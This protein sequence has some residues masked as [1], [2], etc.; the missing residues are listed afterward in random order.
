MLLSIWLQLL[1]VL[2]GGALLTINE[3]ARF[4]AG[5]STPT[6]VLEPLEQ[7]PGWQR[8]SLALDAGW[9]KLESNRLS[10]MSAW[11]ETEI[12]PVI[13]AKL[14]LVYL[15]GGPDAITVDVIYA[16]APIYVLAGLERVG[17]VPALETLTPDEL[18]RGLSSLR[19]AIRTTIDQSFFI[20][21]KIGADLKRS[22]LQG[23]LP[24][25]LLMLARH[26][27]EVLEA[28]LMYLDEAGAPTPSTGETP[29]RGVPGLRLRFRRDGQGQPR[30]LYYFSQDVTN[31]AL[32][33]RP[34]L[35]PFLKSLGP[36]NSF[37]KAAS[38]ILHDRHFSKTRQAV[39]DG[40]RSILQDDSGVAFQHLPASKWSL[41]FYGEY[42]P[43]TGSFSDHYQTNLKAAWD[44]APK[45]PLPF[46]TGYKHQ[47]GSTMMLAIKRDGPPDAGAR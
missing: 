13:E 30:E 6:S 22:K 42:T 41:T 19:S 23:V 29:P 3:Q 35:L 5:L 45:R 34:G 17:S 18:E 25:I 33:A 4:L 27:D 10:K 47:F 26:G 21:S 11:A 40:S 36:F 28:Q 32:P 38:F 1:G 15:F 31:S 2:D 9:A 43:Q 20:T 46:R 12:R 16:E 44:A 37:F 24:V 39:L 8:H 7:T 14:P